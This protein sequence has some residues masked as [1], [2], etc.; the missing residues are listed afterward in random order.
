MPWLSLPSFL[1]SRSFPLPPARK[2]RLNESLSAGER[3]ICFR[4]ER[5]VL[6]RLGPGLRTVPGIQV[7]CGRLIGP[8]PSPRSRHLFD[9]T[10]VYHNRGASFCRPPTRRRPR[11]VGLRRP[12]SGRSFQGYDAYQPLGLGRQASVSGR[13]LFPVVSLLRAGWPSG[14]PRRCRGARR[15]VKLSPRPLC[16][17]DTPPETNRSERR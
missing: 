7:G 3:P 10:S 4:S 6:P 14:S 12:I 15:P 17:D 9:L 1:M 8:E 2:E 5:P 13:A 11:H 16:V